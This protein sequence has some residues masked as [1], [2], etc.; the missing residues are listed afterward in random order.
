MFFLFGKLNDLVDVVFI[1][2]DNVLGFMF[3][4]GGVNMAIVQLQV[5]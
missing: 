3:V 5:G 1:R 4:L 2:N